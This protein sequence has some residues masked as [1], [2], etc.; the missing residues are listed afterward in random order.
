MRDRIP[1]L[2]L[3]SPRRGVS[4]LGVSFH[5]PRSLLLSIALRLTLTPVQVQRGVEIRYLL[6]TVHGV[7]L[8]LRSFRTRSERRESLL[9]L[10]LRHASLLELVVFGPVLSHILRLRTALLIHGVAHAPTSLVYQLMYFAWIELRVDAIARIWPVNS[11]TGMEKRGR[12][13]LLILRL[14]GR[15][16]DHPTPA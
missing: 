2:L 5:F 10:L 14:R 16:V 12:F 4:I 3:V 15:H 13:T 11:A 1:V 9:H 7:G 8:I 6:L